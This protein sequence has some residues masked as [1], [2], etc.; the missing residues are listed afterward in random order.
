MLV[1]NISYITINYITLSYNRADR[2]QRFAEK[3]NRDIRQTENT[4][5]EVEVR[6]EEEVRRVDRLHP[7]DAKRNCDELESELQQCEDTIRSLHSDVKVLRDNKYPEAPT[8]HKRW[9][10]SHSVS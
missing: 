2:L 3:I 8:L 6:I 1:D 5:N 10:N 9:N 7:T 4:L